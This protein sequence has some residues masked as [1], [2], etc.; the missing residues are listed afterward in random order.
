MTT[1]TIDGV[2]TVDRA[3]VIHEFNASAERIFGWRRDEIVGRN[4]RLLSICCC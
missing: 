1:T 2:V 4:I 3:G